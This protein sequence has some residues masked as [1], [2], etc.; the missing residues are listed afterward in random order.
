MGGRQGV[1]LPPAGVSALSS[2][3]SDSLNARPAAPAMGAMPAGLLLPPNL[4]Q[5][6][7]L[8]TGY[9]AAGLWGCSS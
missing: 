8:P 7:L 5:G 9:L 1:P 4:S 3:I 6:K 2:T